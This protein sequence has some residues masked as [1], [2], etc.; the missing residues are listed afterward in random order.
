MV[1]GRQH[2][3]ICCNYIWQLILIDKLGNRCICLSLARGIMG[4]NLHKNG[5]ENCLKPLVCYFCLF[6]FTSYKKCTKTASRAGCKA[7]NTFAP[8]VLFNDIK[9]CTGLFIHT[10]NTCVR[11]NLKKI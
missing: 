11:Y 1:L 2:M 4:L 9:G 8:I 10:I 3:R 7:N 5:I 6:F